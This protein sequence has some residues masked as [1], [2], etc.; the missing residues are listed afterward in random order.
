MITIEISK[1][2]MTS[3]YF[4][5]FPYSNRLRVGDGEGD[6]EGDGVGDGVGDEIERREEVWLGGK[7]NIWFESWD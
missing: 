7:K 6:G 2:Y 3:S 4:L 5:F 1:Q